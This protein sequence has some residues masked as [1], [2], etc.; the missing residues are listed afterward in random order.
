MSKLLGQPRPGLTGGIGPF[1]DY[2]FEFT[3][4]PN[5]AR[6]TGCHDGYPSYRIYE[7]GRLIYYYKH[8]PW[9]QGKLL[10]NCDRKVELGYTYPRNPLPNSDEQYPELCK[11]SFG[12][13][14]C[15]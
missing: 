12:S 6:V 8:K 9:R 10:G 5:N 2:S 3:G 14:F 11:E 4:A 15:G 1:I 7:N 13:I